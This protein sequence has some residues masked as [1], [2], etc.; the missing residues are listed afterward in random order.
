[1]DC[2][3]RQTL[4]PVFIKKKKN[5]QR[6]YIGR[7]RI[8][9]NLIWP[10][11]FGRIWPIFVDRIWPDRISIWGA[12]G[13]GA[14]RGGGPSSFS[15]L[16]SK[17]RSLLPSL[18]VFSWNSG[19]VCSIRKLK[20]ARLEF[21]GC[22]AKPRRPGL[23]GPLLSHLLQSAWVLL[24]NCASGRANHQLRSVRP[25]LVAEFAAG[26]DLGMRQCFQTILNIP[27]ESTAL[28]RA[29]TSLPFFH[30]AN[31]ACGAPPT[32]ASVHGGPVGVTFCP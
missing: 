12:L 31:W 2:F 3:S 14:R 24:L 18:E 28:T 7:D 27:E 15:S 32:P 25:E 10:S 8:W 19:S 9:P 17:I 11:L 22:R 29:I 1:M 21:S 30:W 26:H 23:V 4:F 13:V 20:C 16:C 5:G 6:W